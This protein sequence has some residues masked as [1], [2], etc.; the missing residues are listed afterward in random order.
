[1]SGIDLIANSGVSGNKII[2]SPTA[3]TA[4]TPDSA[5]NPMGSTS[6]AMARV[7]NMNSAKTTA[8]PTGSRAG[9]P[10]CTKFGCTTSNVPTNPTAQAARRCGPTSS[11]RYTLPSSNIIN[12]MTNA[13]AM[14]SASSRYCSDENINVI[15][16][17]CST[18]RMAVSRINRAPCGIGYFSSQT[19]GSSSAACTVNRTSTRNPTDISVPNT[20]AMASPSGAST[21]NPSMSRMPRRGR[22]IIGLR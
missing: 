1:M 20:L 7:T 16:A 12:G 9:S 17:M 14:A 15:P 10:T 6:L 21:Q 5:C 22:S 2:A 4:I 8:T 13:I 18:V 11:F 19:N 3:G